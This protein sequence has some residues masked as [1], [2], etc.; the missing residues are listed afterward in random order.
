MS[1][2]LRAVLSEPEAGRFGPEA[3]LIRATVRSFVATEILPHVDRWEEAGTFPRELYP[4]AGDVG[5]L[6]V[7]YPED[8]GGTPT[9][10]WGQI[11]T[12]E[13]MA[14]CTSGGIAASLGS[15][16]IALPPIVA[17]GTPEQQA[18][19]VSPVLAGDRIA[20][21]AIT[22]PGAGSDVANLMTRAVRDGDHYL[23]DGSKT[24]ITSGVRADQ[25][26]VAV[27]TGGPGHDGISLLVVEA[28]VDGF[29]RSGPMAKMG[30]WPSDT[31]TLYFDRV[32]VPVANRVGPENAGFRIIMENFQMERLQLAVSGYVTAE[33]AIVEAWRYATD[34]TVFGRPVA[35]FQANRHR[36]V[37]LVAETTAAK[38]FTYRAAEG[39]ER[40]ED[41]TT[42]I[43]LAKLLAT[44]AAEHATYAA[45]QL[46]G[47]AGYL[48][49]NVA[50]RLYRDARILA[51]GGGTSEIMREIVAKR[52][53]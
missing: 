13:E 21:L 3:D 40:G 36:F 29:T 33:T 44:A 41:R 51:I 5:I 37:D 39:I 47:G 25:I 27:R 2:R 34:R 1:D 19:F 26:T 8:V 42:E 52:I 7:G 49:G 10:L 17:H 43:S 48:R 9:G 23:I 24:F 53:L 4:R 45:V 28:D 20:A 12:W 50:E 14:R 38:E 31:A 46:F 22:E 18:R 15:H 35:G 16:H 30:W 32:R 11:A 6:G